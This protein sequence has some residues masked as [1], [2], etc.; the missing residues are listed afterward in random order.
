MNDRTSKLNE[1]IHQELDKI[2]LK[3]V[4][5]PDGVIVTLRRAKTDGDMKNCQIIISVWPEERKLE[6]LKA[7]RKVA[8]HLQTLLNKKVNIHHTPR[9]AFRLAT[10]DDDKE[11]NEAMELDS[12]FE[13]ISKEL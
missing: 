2:I 13:Q 7:L 11:Q 8:G 10:P 3:E 4:E 9:I 12:L 1:L 5:M 6:G